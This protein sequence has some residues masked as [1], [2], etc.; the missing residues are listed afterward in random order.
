MLVHNCCKFNNKD[1]TK[2][3]HLHN[4]VYGVTCPTIECGATYRGETGS[5]LHLRVEE[6][7]GKYAK[8]NFFQHT[9]NSGHEPVSLTHFKIIA[10]NRGSLMNRKIIESLVIQAKKPTLNIQQVSIPL[11]LFN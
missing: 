9:L 7:A 1:L 8:S 5:R 2:T 6:H 4:V 11:K 3:E 10:V